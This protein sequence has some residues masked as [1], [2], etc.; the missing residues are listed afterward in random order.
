M[1]KIFHYFIIIT[2]ISF[3][4]SSCQKEEI[5]P[6]MQ[7]ESTQLTP[8]QLDLKKKMDQAAQILVQFSN[9]KE[10]M[11]EV[12]K[13]ID[14]K[15]YRDDYVK[16]KDLFQP[17]SNNQLKSF[18]ETKFAKLFREKAASGLKSS[19][20]FDLEQFLIDNDLVLYVPYPVEDYPTDKQMPTISYHPLDND[21]VNIGYR[22]SMEKSSNA[23]QTV[24]KVNEQYSQNYPVY[25]IAPDDEIIGSGGTGG[26]NTGGETGTGVGTSDNDPFKVKLVH[27]LVTKQY[28]GIFNGGS[29]FNFVFIKG[30]PD[31][32]KATAIETYKGT[33]NFTRTEIRKMKRWVAGKK[34]RTMEYKYI[35]V[36]LHPSWKKEE[37][38]NYLSAVEIDD[39]G[40]VT[41]KAS[42]KVKVKGVTLNASYT[43]T[44]KTEDEPVAKLQLDRTEFLKGERDHSREYGT[45]KGNVVRALNTDVLITTHVYF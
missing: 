23:V 36:T 38:A 34:N 30:E 14:L 5:N 44:F 21:S 12:Q 11:A 13:M 33:L 29:E 40:D 39:K 28:D 32:N 37:I 26:G 31:G 22:L 3:A 7:N 35:G 15:M 1:K 27:M 9:D 42:V 45:Y 4:L 25:I 8:E 20:S 43:K 24:P 17:E 2:I 10:A 6:A 16:F 18:G 41:I 19:D